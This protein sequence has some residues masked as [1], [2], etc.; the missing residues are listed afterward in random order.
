MVVF[1]YFAGIPRARRGYDVRDRWYICGQLSEAFGCAVG[2]DWKRSR[3]QPMFW[4]KK[5]SSDLRRI[6]RMRLFGHAEERSLYV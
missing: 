2:R 4:G 5:P 1:F 6:K 3:D